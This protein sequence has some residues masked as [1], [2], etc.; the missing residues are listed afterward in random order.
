MRHRRRRNYGSR[1]SSG[2]S[3]KIW[4]KLIIAGIILFFVGVFYITATGGPT[5]A[6]PGMIISL[7]G[8]ILVVV[9]VLSGIAR[10]FNR[11]M[12]E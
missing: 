2:K 12:S 9:G 6:S 1:R 8:V 5:I 10:G 7:I 11:I 4:I 3:L